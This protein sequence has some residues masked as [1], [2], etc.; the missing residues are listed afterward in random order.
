MDELLKKTNRIFDENRLIGNYDATEDEFSLMLDYVGQL[1]YDI[2]NGG[3]F[4]EEHYKL[5]FFTLVEITKRWKDSDNEDDAEENSRFWDYISRFLINED[6]ISN[7]LY[8]GLTNIINQ[9]NKN[10]MLPTV[11]RGQR[12]YATLMMH[13]YA[14]KNS[15]FSF[16]DLCY[17]IFKKDLDFGFTSDDEWLCE[18]VATQLKTVLGGGYR[19]DKKVSIGS[20]VY[21]IK[22]GLRSF[23]Q[24]E[25]LSEDFMEFIKNTFYQINKLFNKDEVDED[26]RLNRY[27]VEWWKNKIEAEKISDDTTRKKRVP[28]VLKENIVAKFIRDGNLVYL[29]IPSIRLDDS[30]STVWL[31]IYAGG[32][33]VLSDEMRTKRGELVVA[34]SQIELNLDDL[35]MS[36][37]KIDIRVEIKENDI[38]IFDSER[39]KTTSLNR[40]FILFEGEKEVLSQINKPTNYFVYSRDIDALENQPDELTT[41]GPNLYNI[42]PKVGESLIGITKHVFFVDKTKTTNLGKNACLIGELL[43]VEWFLDEISCAVYTN[44]VKLMV[45]ETANLKALELRIDKNAYKLHELTYERIVSNC[46]QFGLKSAGL[47]PENY[48][49]EISL[50]SYEKEAIILTETI[51]VLPSL[52][53]QFNHPFY[54]GEIEHKLKIINGNEVQELTWSNQDNEI[55]CPIND[56]VLL[57]KIP[58]L[59]WRI[60]NNEWHNEPINRKLWYRDFLKNGDILEIDTPKD[61]EEIITFAIVNENSLPLKIPKNQS[62]NFEVG[63]AIYNNEGIT[64][65]PVYFFYR[66]REEVFK[67]FTV[68]TKE[69]FIANPLEYNEGKVFWNVENTFIG[70]KN[71]D[72]FLILKSKDN[73][74]RIKIAHKNSEI[75]N[76]DKDKYIVQVKIKNKNI[77]LNTDSYQLIYDGDLHVGSPEELRFKHKRINL[78]SANCFSKKFE[79]IIFRQKYFVDKLKFVQEDENS[80]YVGQL[81][82][83]DHNDKI[84]VLNSMI[85]EKEEYDKTNPVRIELRDKYTLWLVAGWEGGNDFIGNLFCDKWH[86]LICNIQKQDTRYDEINL[87]KFREEDV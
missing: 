47:I 22:I 48:P 30:N 67:L 17:N 69:H 56:G 28:T 5:I 3:E 84:T 11:Q 68:S 79:W 9:L 51:I 74:F 42:Y 40:E 44:S 6:T 78:I 12:Y 18:L 32:E 75:E 15:I 46:Y 61:Y 60:N 72:F 58:Y 35:L 38:V 24:H 83:V 1:C 39:N 41:C 65:I 7:R 34:T 14:P 66:R 55:K 20:S 71:S 19:E 25:D 45:P 27:I 49:T 63:R 62:E 85:N 52:D 81:C 31:N 86:K 36:C 87:Y 16:F 73:N 13:S 50:Y 2:H 53:I 70:E 77:F 21:S 26:T 10:Q 23:S 33:N 76:L 37:D 54:Y 59:R 43:D 64:D 57:I 4:K 29:C 80:Y 8:I 82:A